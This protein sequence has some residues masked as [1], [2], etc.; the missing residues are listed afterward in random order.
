MNTNH[1]PTCE[2]RIRDI[3]DIP[4]P[5]VEMNFIFSTSTRYFTSELRS[6]VKYQVEHEKIKFISTSG[7]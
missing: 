6:L 4:C 7:L 5:L 1:S 2:T 3:E